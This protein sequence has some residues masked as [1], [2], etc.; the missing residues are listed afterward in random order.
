MIFHYDLISIILYSTLVSNY[1]KL[2]GRQCMKNKF[3]QTE[4][5]EHAKDLCTS[6]D[7]C[8]GVYDNYCDDNPPF[9]LCHVDKRDLFPFEDS[10]LTPLS[11]VYEKDGRKS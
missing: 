2:N 6:D 4:T 8:G 11:C 9:Y 10:A 3:R 7:A 5:L 1:R